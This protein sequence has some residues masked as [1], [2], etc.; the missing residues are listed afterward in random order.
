M[1][2]CPNCHRE[3]L[4]PRPVSSLAAAID[5][6]LGIADRQ[7]EARGAAAALRSHLL[8]LKGELL[9]VCMDCSVATAA[10]WLQERAGVEASAQSATPAEL[11]ANVVRLRTHAG[12]LG[13]NWPAPARPGFYERAPVDPAARRGE[14]ERP[15]TSTDE[16]DDG[17]K[18]GA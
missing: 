3:H 15:H 6:A 14:C 2:T 10:A 4:G 8:L 7:P 13:L 9:G 1:T 11:P 17:P 5:G 16:H 18:K 12:R